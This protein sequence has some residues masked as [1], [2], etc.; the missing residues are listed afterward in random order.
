MNKWKNRAVN[1]IGPQIQGRNQRDRGNQ[2]AEK[3]IVLDT[4]GIENGISLY[5]RGIKIH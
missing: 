3:G 1:S 4:K 5:G 2:G